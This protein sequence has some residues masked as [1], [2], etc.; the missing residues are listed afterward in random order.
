LREAIDRSVEPPGWYF[1]LLA[2]DRLMRGEY[3]AMRREAERAALSGRPI[4]EALLAIAAGALGDR[5]AARTAISR[6]PPD[7]DI[8]AYARRHGA[9]DEI[10]TA[11]VD[12]LHLA[13]DL[14]AQPQALPPS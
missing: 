14:A 10:V 9:I 4:S 1:H 12:G 2:I 11:L 5:E 8:E 13:E 7:W 3:V 6:I